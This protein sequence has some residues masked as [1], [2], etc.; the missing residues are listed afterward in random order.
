MKTKI[1]NR[2]EGDN[3]Q[4]RIPSRKIGNYSRQE[5]NRENN[6]VYNK[7]KGEK[8][9]EITKGEV[10][11]RALELIGIALS[12]LSN[13]TRVNIARHIQKN[14]RATFEELRTEF[15]LNNNSLTFHLQKLQDAYIV[16]QMKNRA[17]YELGELGDVMLRLLDTIEGDVAQVLGQLIV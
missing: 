8:K 14:K 1:E 5:N 6:R 10:R 4:F 12:A 16:T 2:K 15:N 17:P 13:N 3:E 11:E 7:E 9:E